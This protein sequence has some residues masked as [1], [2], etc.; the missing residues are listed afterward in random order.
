VLVAR[1]Q[2]ERLAVAVDPRDRDLVQA[3]DLHLQARDA[4]LQTVRML[5]IAHPEAVVH[6]LGDGTQLRLGR[7]A[8]G[9]RQLRIGLRTHEHGQRRDAD[10]HHERDPRH[11]PRKRVEAPQ[12][13]DHPPRRRADQG[14]A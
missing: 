12:G 2:Q 8:V 5:E 11:Q 13:A 1:L 9:A 4:A 3:R 14:C 7:L 10:E 6:R